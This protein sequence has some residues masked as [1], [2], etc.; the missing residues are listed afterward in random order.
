MKHFHFTFLFLPVLA[1]GVWAQPAAPRR[2]TASPQVS[3]GLRRSELRAALKQPQQAQENDPI[4]DAQAQVPGRI[5]DR[6]LS[7]QQRA[8]LRQQLRQLSV[9]GLVNV[10]TK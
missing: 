7:A 8:D 3:S 1:V 2:E 9:D 4:I 10:T 5:I 6:R